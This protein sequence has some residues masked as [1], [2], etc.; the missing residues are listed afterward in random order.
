MSARSKFTFVRL[1]FLNMALAGHI[2]ATYREGK[3]RDK[4][5]EKYFPTIPQG[6]LANYGAPSPAVEVPQQP[7]MPPKSSTYL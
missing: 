7:I 6:P 4:L 1:A 2:T 5:A 3:Y